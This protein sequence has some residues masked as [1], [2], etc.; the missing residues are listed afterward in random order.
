MVVDGVKKKWNPMNVPTQTDV[1]VSSLTHCNSFD[2]YGLLA[3]ALGRGPGVSASNLDIKWEQAKGLLVS[4]G[5][6]P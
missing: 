6:M 5:A 2:N 4:V 3:K 1:L